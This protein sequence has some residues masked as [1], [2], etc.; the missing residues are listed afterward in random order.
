MNFSIGSTALPP[1]SPSLLLSK[2]PHTAH[3]QELQH[4]LS[5]KSLAHQILL[6]EHDKLLAAFSRSR[7]R[8]EA[9]D[10]KSQVSE[11]EINELSEINSRFQAQI[12]AFEIQVEELQKGRDETMKQS[13]ANV[14]QY[15]KIM[16]MSSKLQAQATND[17]RRWKEDRER[18]EKEKR[19]L[20]QQGTLD[21][22]QSPELQPLTDIP[23]SHPSKLL[24]HPP[25]HTEPPSQAD[26]SIPTTSPADTLPTTSPSALRSEISL[27]RQKNQDAEVLLAKLRA[28]AGNIDDVIGILEVISR[29]VRGGDGKEEDTEKEK[30]REEDG[31]AEVDTDMQGV[32]G[33]DM[34][35]STE[36]EAEVR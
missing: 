24:P 19:E 6:G 7:T 3:L 5:T 15:M 25:D 32:D 23:P 11:H 13:V 35:K 30:E 18:W 31:A 14:E 20:L 8:C 2:S 33:A 26:L 9:L 34:A 16:N 10:K 1:M 17:L 21:R 22:Q 12:D 28:Q 27:L 4:Q 29:R 36:E